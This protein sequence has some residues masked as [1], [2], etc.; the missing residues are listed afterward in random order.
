MLLDESQVRREGDA[1]APLLSMRAGA[2]PNLLLVGD[3]P[4]I[5]ALVLAT[6][7]RWRVRN[8]REREAGTGLIRPSIHISLYG[9]GAE[10]RVATLRETWRPEPE[11]LTLEGRD[12]P[13]PS[14]AG[15]ESDGWLRA[16]DR[17]DHAI[18]AC[19]DELQG[20]ALTL[21]VARALGA[22]ARVTRVTTQFENALDAYVE[23][24]TAGSHAL[25]PTEVKSIADLG[26]R[27][28]QMSE[29]QNVQRLIEALERDRHHRSTGT[30]RS[31][32]DASPPPPAPDAA[33]Q[34]RA[35]LGRPDLRIRSDTTW[36]VRPAERPLLNAMLD[37]GPQLQP[38]PLSAILRAGLRVDLDSAPSLLSA[39]HRLSEQGDP[40]ALTAWCE[41]LRLTRSDPDQRAADLAAMQEV[42]TSSDPRVQRLIALAA[43]VAGDRAGLGTSEPDGAV[44]ADAAR[45][46]I[47]GGAADAMTAQSRRELEPL[48]ETALAAYD[49]MIL[50]GEPSEGL[51][52][53]VSRIARHHDLQ[54]IGY[55]PPG[56]G[57]FSPLEPLA[58]W[59]DILRAG[60]AAR[61]VALVACPGGPLTLQEVSLA[62]ALGARVGWLDPAGEAPQALD[63]LLPLGAAGVIELPPD[64]MT[65]RAFLAPTTLSE[66]PRE[67]VA[68]YFHN[69]YRR[70]QRQRKS[71]GDP[72]LARW[73]E[74][75]PA[76]RAS[77]LAQADDIPNKLAL[78]GKRL[79]R[80]GDLLGLSPEQVE[81]LAEV[82]HGRWN[83]ERLAAGW[84]AGPR[85]VGRSTS[86]DLIPWTELPHDVR[87]YDREAV[88]NIAPALA[89]AGWGVVDG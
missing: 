24:R 73:E 65:I 35:V 56:G 31:L 60:C 89:D 59:T 58:M 87:E 4:L 70:R 67:A 12:S 11:V 44:L 1:L 49:G 57:E 41:Y 17:G 51:P 81:R 75:P 9:P 27:P 66:P 21:T 52:G 36:R 33:A 80:G 7:R 63:D 46:T 45:V 82:E 85:Q 32:T 16:P 25:A 64:A 37:L 53:L 30:V 68:R 62:R 15:L 86:P 34:A 23:E 22:T 79:A 18:I 2:S 8:L 88:R 40:A 26:A 29:R 19:T 48:L 28:E 77:N 74:L 10:H 39:A 69:D 84:R 72:A 13:P 5:D 83:F 76:L 6:L 78:I 55:P 43:A 3:H 47:F 61:N 42:G 71:F 54:L 14:H 50:A 38:V 20:I